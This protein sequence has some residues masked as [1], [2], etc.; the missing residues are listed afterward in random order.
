M[1][2]ARLRPLPPRLPPPSPRLGL[3]D[4]KLLTELPVTRDLV[5]G[6]PGPGVRAP[7]RAWARGSPHRRPAAGPAREPTIPPRLQVA[8]PG[9]PQ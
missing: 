4:F 7:S 6:P 8:G 5:A 3:G 9:V 1:S 2:L